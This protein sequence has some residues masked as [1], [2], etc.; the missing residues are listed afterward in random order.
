MQT[1]L[2]LRLLRKDPTSKSGYRIVGHMRISGEVADVPFGKKRLGMNVQYSYDGKKWMQEPNE[3]IFNSTELG[4]KVPVM[5]PL[6][7]MMIGWWF[8]GD[9]IGYDADPGDY[10][11]TS[12]HGELKYSNGV[13]VVN[14]LNIDE[15]PAF[16]ARR[17]GNIHE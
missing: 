1:E 10:R 15:L 8:E 17:I 3:L 4:V 13:W 14:S 5:L 6:K 2:M 16:N 7:A 12:V 11:D 9:V